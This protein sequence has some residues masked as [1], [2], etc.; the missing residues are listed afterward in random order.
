MFKLGFAMEKKIGFFRLVKLGERD[1]SHVVVF[2]VFF[3]LE[4][5]EVGFSLYEGKRAVWL[6]LIS[7]LTII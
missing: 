2:L 4:L 6:R 7:H 3:V 5:S 1:I